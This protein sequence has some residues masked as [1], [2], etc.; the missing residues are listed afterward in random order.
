[1]TRRIVVAVTGASG[2]PLAV[3]LLRHLAD[4]EVE[5]H[6]I[7][8]G[9][10]EKVLEYETGMTPAQ[11]GRLASVTRDV[12]DLSAPLA[13]GTFHT[14]G[15]VVIP[16]TMKTLAA[17]ANGLADNLIAR[18]ADVTLKE[19]RRLVLVARESPLNLI[20]IENMKAVTLAGAVVLP[21]VLSFYSKPRS[22]DDL[23][24]HVSGKVLDAL[25]IEHE[26]LKRWS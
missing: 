11:V 20:Q 22:I 23:I 21:P 16:C 25:G 4:L 13:S 7:V 3:N 14:D 6:L 2:A 19:R 17:V 5:T 24:D 18:A 1:M 26:V 12:R 10:A 9:T 15:M 8:S